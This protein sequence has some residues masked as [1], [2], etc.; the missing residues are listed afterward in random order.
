MVNEPLRSNLN[1]LVE[2]LITINHNELFQNPIVRNITDRYPY[3]KSIL[4]IDKF[5]EGDDFNAHWIL[6]NQSDIVLRKL[7]ENESVKS[8][9]K[10]FLIKKHN[11]GLSKI[12]FKYFFST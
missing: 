11:E 8:S 9:L 1:D 12:C 5:I 6:E 4:G 7:S 2:V 10:D 3:Y